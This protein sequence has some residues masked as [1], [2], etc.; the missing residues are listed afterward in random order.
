MTY[1]DLCI[2]VLLRMGE[3]KNVANGNITETT[4]ISEYLKL[5][6]LFL[7]EGATLLSTAGKYMQNS[8]TAD[9]DGVFD[10]TTIPNF[11]SIVKILLDGEN[12]SDYRI[13]INR[14]LNIATGEYTI[15]YNAYPTFTTLD[16]NTTIDIDKEIYLL[17][18]L[19]IEGKIRLINDEDYSTLIL[20]EFE[21]RRNELMS[22][23]N[24]SSLVLTISGETV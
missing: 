11:Y 3:S 15:F 5:I 17:L 24:Q 16:Y 14:Y 8:Y 13:D 10:L 20:N 12:Y 1:K 4:T 23:S 19:Y 22:R 9:I 2:D 21:Q 18:Q 6:P 7:K